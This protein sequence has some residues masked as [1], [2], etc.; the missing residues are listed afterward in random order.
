MARITLGRIACA[1]VALAVVGVTTS[2]AQPLDKR[3]YFTFSGPVAI[4]GKT[5]PA[6][7]YLFRIANDNARQDV[8]QVL[9]ADGREPLAMFFAIPAQRAKA[10][11]DPAIGFKETPEGTPPAVGVWWHPQNLIG[12]EF[13]YPREQA[14]ALARETGQPVLA[15]S[16]EAPAAAPVPLVR[17]AP[18]GEETPVRAEAPPAPAAAGGREVVGEAAPP[19][20]AVA[21]SQQARA[22]LPRTAGT[23]PIVALG[24]LLLLLAAAGLRLLRTQA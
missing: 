17:V 15:T 20:L 22:E 8:V 1:V 16:A 3:T 9:T 7:K 10:S 19:S 11:D 2:E 6:G 23:L 13:V 24:G 18:S 14:R 5:L 4:P 21:E 12:H